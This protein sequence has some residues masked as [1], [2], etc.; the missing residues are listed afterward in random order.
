MTR[1]KKKKPTNTPEFRRGRE[2]GVADTLVLFFALMMQDDGWDAEKVA[3]FGKRVLDWKAYTEEPN[4]PFY[5]ST[6]EKILAEQGVHIAR[7][8]I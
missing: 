2:K 5:I 7:D 4:L 1:V 8:S 3:K 6:G